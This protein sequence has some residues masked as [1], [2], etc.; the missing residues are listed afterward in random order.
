[1][2]NGASGQRRPDGIGLQVRQVRAY[3]EHAHPRGAM[4]REVKGTVPV[5]NYGSPPATPVQAQAAYF[6]ISKNI[7]FMP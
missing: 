5:E 1:M 3:V 6:V 7:G 2:S 4:K